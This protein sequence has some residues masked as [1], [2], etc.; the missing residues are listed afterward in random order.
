MA[1]IDKI[2]LDSTTYDIASPVGYGTCSTAADVAAKEVTISN[3]DWILQVGS[4]IGVKFTASNTA[5]TPTLNVNSTG[6]KNI[7][8]NNAKYTSTSSNIG[9]Y[10]GRVLYYMYDGTYWVWLNMG[11]LDGNSNT[12]PSVQM[13]TAAGTAAKV[14]TCTNHTLLANSFVHVNVRYTNTYAGAI[15]LNIDS[16]GAKPIYLNGSATSASN[17]SL[18]AG[19][20]IVYYNGTNFYFRTDGKL[21]A[22][23]TGNAA[24]ATKVSKALTFK[25]D[26]SGAASNTTFDGSTARTISYNS[27]GA[28]SGSHTHTASY[29]PA[30]SVSKPGVTLTSSAVA[31][32]DITAW[33]AG[34]HSFTQGS[35]PSFSASVTN[36]N[37]PFSFGAGSLPTHS[38]TAPSLSYTARSINHVTAAALSATPTFTGTPATITT[39][40]PV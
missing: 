10:A 22:D 26:G 40:T 23:I 32:D 16:A 4:I 11:S 3:T 25:D 9:G 29:T 20:Y 39:G 18:K 36:Q 13:E 17:Y 27:V 24:T 5:S 28:A 35:L 1:I 12:V 7:W 19:T 30:G 6:A 37:L 38:Y 31:C 33:S 14:G 34:S 21:T 15:T 8:Y 2:K